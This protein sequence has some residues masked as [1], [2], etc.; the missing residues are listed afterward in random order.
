MESKA[1]HSDPRLAMLNQ[2][3]RVDLTLI[4]GARRMLSNG[5]TPDMVQHCQQTIETSTRD[6][7]TV[8]ELKKQWGL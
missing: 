1:N 3:I 7:K 5:C 8:T 6:M 4:T 2:M